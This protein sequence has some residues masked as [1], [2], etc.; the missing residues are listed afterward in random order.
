MNGQVNTKIAEENIMCVT[1]T[2]TK[3][4]GEKTKYLIDAINNFTGDEV[5]FVILNQ[6]RNIEYQCGVFDYAGV[7]E[8]DLFIENNLFVKEL[9][10]WAKKLNRATR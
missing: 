9:G 3:C 2:L 6:N 5:G 8:V 4:E 1:F 7:S 10:S